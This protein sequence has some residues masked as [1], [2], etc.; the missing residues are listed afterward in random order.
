MI[1]PPSCRNFSTNISSLGGSLAHSV[2]GIDLAGT[3][4]KFTKGF[5]ELQQSVK[6][7]L[8][9]TDEDAVT[10]LPEGASAYLLLSLGR[11]LRCTR[12]I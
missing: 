12:S 10:E 9:R 6:E 11:Q 1:R 5:S 7:N 2:Q 8:G 4:S 3:G